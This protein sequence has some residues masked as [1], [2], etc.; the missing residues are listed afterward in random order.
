MWRL[1]QE[2]HTV[3]SLE[4]WY[5]LLLSFRI[6]SIIL[7]II[8]TKLTA[9]AVNQIQSGENDICRNDAVEFAQELFRHCGKYLSPYSTRTISNGEDIRALDSAES[10]TASAM[11]KSSVDGMQVVNGACH[12]HNFIWC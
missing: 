4:E 3:D 12:I 9:L 5:T 1:N 6:V 7:C 8:A 10:I 11:R 2:L